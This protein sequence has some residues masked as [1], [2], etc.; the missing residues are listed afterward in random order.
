[1][2]GYREITE[3]L[4]FDLIA[5]A[6]P[7][8]V[9]PRA[10][11]EVIGRFIRQIDVDED[12]YRREYADVARAIERGEILSAR[13]HFLEFGYFEGRNPTPPAAE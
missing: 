7:V 2:P 6:N 13:D 8:S 5:A 11:L 1:M 10:L 12:G 9:D 4:G 3:I